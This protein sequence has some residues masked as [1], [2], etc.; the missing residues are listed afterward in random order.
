MAG[1]IHSRLVLS[2]S[3]VGF[4]PPCE[5]SYRGVKLPRVSTA[6]GGDLTCGAG[7]ICRRWTRFARGRPGFRRRAYRCSLGTNTVL[8]NVTNG[9]FVLLFDGGAEN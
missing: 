9:L 2:P 3:G 4:S 8:G 7:P 5:I 6:L 1:V